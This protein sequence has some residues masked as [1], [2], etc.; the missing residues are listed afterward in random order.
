VIIEGKTREERDEFEAQLANME[1]R[2]R[3]V[4]VEKPQPKRK[5]PPSWWKG[6]TA[7]AESSMQ[8]AR[9]YGFVIGATQ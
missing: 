8:A 2:A 9:D 1:A 3:E 4:E 7:A 5:K 6:D